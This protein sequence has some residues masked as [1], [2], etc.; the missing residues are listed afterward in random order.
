MQPTHQTSDRLMAEARL[1]PN[2][3]SGAYAWQSVL[4]SGA[5][6]AFGSDFPVES[7]NPFPGLSAAVSRQDLNGQPPGGW[8]PAE[9]LSFEQALNGFTGGAAYAGFAET[10]I[11]ALEPGKWADFIFV[12]RDVS[13]VDAQALARTQ[14]LE[15]WVAGKKVWEQASSAAGGA[16]RG[17]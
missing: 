4:K 10:K 9:K 7:P 1:G 14:V 6:L 16:E 5:R 15:T 12:D 17:K 11:G 13:S 8:L 2:R 3:L